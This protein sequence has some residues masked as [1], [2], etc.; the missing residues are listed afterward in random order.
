MRTQLRVKMKGSW[1]DTDVGNW[2][3]ITGRRNS[4]GVGQTWYLKGWWGPAGEGPGMPLEGVW[5]YEVRDGLA[6]EGCARK[7]ENVCVL[8]SY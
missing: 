2:R 4:A 8:D 7:N 5:T 1:P 6:W 3:D